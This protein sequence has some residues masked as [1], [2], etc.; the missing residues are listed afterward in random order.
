MAWTNY[1]T[2]V[3]R[4][5]HI[6]AKF[7]RAS[8][9]L[10]PAGGSAEVIVS[11]YPWWEHPRYLNAIDRGEPWGFSGY[12]SGKREVRV[13]GGR[14]AGCPS[15]TETGGR[16]VAIEEQHPL[17]W[18]VTGSGTLYVNGPF[19]RQDF[20]KGLMALGLPNVSEADLNRID[21][22]ATDKAPFGVEVPL[23]LMDSV[24]SVFSRL[25]VPV[26]RPDHFNVPPP[27][28]LFLLDGDDYI[29]ARDFEVDVP[30]F[31]HDL[32]GFGRAPLNRIAV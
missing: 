28:I 4:F 16:R 6:D 27:A 23:Q 2:I 18:D 19:K 22:P 7:V 31:V 20:L 17:L 12:E 25:G 30:E 3:D 32:N 5:N 1:R 21:L 13:R 14:A 10:S 8:S 29:I 9:T 15:V 11:L 24:V 26:F